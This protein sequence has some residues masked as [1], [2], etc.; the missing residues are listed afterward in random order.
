MPYLSLR[1]RLRYRLPVSSSPS[2]ANLQPARSAAPGGSSFAR[3][4]A[5]AMTTY[6]EA[7]R[8]KIL[9]S[10]LGATIATL[11]FSLAIGSMSLNENVRVVHHLGAA[12]VSFFAVICA[13]FLGSSL[14]Y[15][16]IEHKTIYMILP[17]PLA[18]WEFIVGKYAG[19]VLT[20]LVFLCLAS[21][22]HWVLWA[23]QTRVA[24]WIPYAAL[25]TIV[26]AFAAQFAW[27]R[28]ASI[29]S[30]VTG[31]FAVLIGAGVVLFAHLPANVAGFSG[32]LA[33][34]EV[35]LVAA[36]A[37]LF[38]SFSTPFLTGLMTLGIW[39]L[40]RQ[41]DDMATVRSN[42]IPEAVRSMLHAL[43]HV[44]PN[45]SLFFPHDRVLTETL[46]DG[47]TPLQYVVEVTTYGS[48]YAGIVLVFACVIFTRR[49]FA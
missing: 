15:K 7:I 22:V 5:I 35:L 49:S 47:A 17:K 24:T 46:P 32:L 40:G 4:A 44:V 13:V 16:E 9:L 45:F 41:A 39:L 42:V 26:V 18:R 1:G 38:S 29:A 31:A 36:I 10:L 20:S 23:A 28:D 33:C 30:I 27:T 48:A 11:L 34:V 25:G 21:S 14:L 19:I 3:V 2:S 43:A 37:M 12:C 8:D 6:R